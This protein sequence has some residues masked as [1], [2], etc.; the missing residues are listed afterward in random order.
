[1]SAETSVGHRLGRGVVRLLA[2][3]RGLPVEL[4]AGVRPGEEVAVRLDLGGPDLAL[5]VPGTGAGMIHSR[6]A[7]A[8]G[9]GA[10]GVKAERSERPEGPLP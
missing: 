8:P 3:P 10:Q 1:M 5:P 4:D 9:P 6:V 7:E 2:R